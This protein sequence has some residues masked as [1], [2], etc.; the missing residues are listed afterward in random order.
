MLSTWIQN[1]TANTKELKI[2]A[3]V[4]ILTTLALASTLFYSIFFTEQPAPT[5]HIENNQH[6]VQITP[7][8]NLPQKAASSTSNAV[9]T[10][11]P[12]PAREKP[13]AA[14]P[15]TPV[16][17]AVTKS[18]TP[19]TASKVEAPATQP[20]T[21]QKIIL[22]Q[23]LYYVQVGAFKEPKRARLM[24]KKMKDKYKHATAT[25][26]GDK[27]IVW[28]GPVVSKD[29]ANRLKTHLLRKEN[30]VGFVVKETQ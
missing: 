26:K 29:D 18:P 9:S 27:Y 10:Q 6:L 14:K 12:T 23:G 22:G 28:V 30:I 7:R 19:A 11:T 4:A 3:I 16:M 8:P 1:L 24:L 5:T 15:E 13:M 20:A 2:A 21:T 17:P 25:P